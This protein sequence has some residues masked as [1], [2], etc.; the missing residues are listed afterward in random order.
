M[1]HAISLHDPQD[2]PW[3]PDLRRLQLDP[4][5]PEAGNFSSIWSHLSAPH[6]SSQLFLL[7]KLNIT[8]C[9]IENDQFSQLLKLIPNIEVLVFEAVDR[10]LKVTD[11]VSK[12]CFQFRPLLT[13]SLSCLQKFLDE[14]NASCTSASKMRFLAVDWTAGSQIDVEAKHRRTKEI[15]VAQLPSLEKLWIC[16]WTRSALMWK[17]TSSGEEALVEYESTPVTAYLDVQTSDNIM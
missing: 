16:D 8:F 2:K 13:P 6:F 17:C 11:H 14:V 9:Y 3:E 15:L 1:L 10:D 4:I 7:S 5:V 12:C